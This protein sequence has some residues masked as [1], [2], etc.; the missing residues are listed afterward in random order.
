MGGSTILLGVCVTVLLVSVDFS[1]SAAI[2]PSLDIPTLTNGADVIVAG[3]IVNRTE[4]GQVIQVAPRGGRVRLKRMRAEVSV[5]RII[6]G[7]QPTPTITFE[8]RIPTL[9]MGGYRNVAMGQY[10]MFFLKRSEGGFRVYDWAYPAVIA[11][12][13]SPEPTGSHLER[14]A[15]EI[16]FVLLSEN[17]MEQDKR[18]AMIALTDVDTPGAR[19][20]Y[21]KLAGSPNIMLRAFAVSSLLSMNDVSILPDAVRLLVSPPS[22]TDKGMLAGIAQVI[23]YQIKDARAIPSLR[24]LLKAPDVFT[25]EASVVALGHTGS[26]EAIVP[27]LEALEDRDR[28]VRSLAMIWLGNLARQ[29]DGSS[30]CDKFTDEQKLLDCW[31]EKARPRLGN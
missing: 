27:L 13:D 3:R 8:F 14:V 4:L 16:L 12:P 31:K 11:A 28:N 20:T 9:P 22:T 29:I 23:R 15:S 6:K 5:R 26:R 18:S 21:R 30:E 1:A 10:G 17:N 2:T 24:Q 19:A 25:R 7:E